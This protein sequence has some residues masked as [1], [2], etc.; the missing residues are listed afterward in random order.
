MDGYGSFSLFQG[1]AGSLEGNKVHTA[2]M[3][4]PVPQAP[5][6][7]SANPQPPRPTTAAATCPGA[8]CPVTST[9]SPAR[10]KQGQC[11][12]PLVATH[13]HGLHPNTLGHRYKYRFDAI[14]RPGTCRQAP[15]R[16]DDKAIFGNIY[17]EYMSP[18]LGFV[19]DQLL[20]LS[21]RVCRHF[22]L[23]PYFTSLSISPTTTDDIR[24][25]LSTQQQP[26]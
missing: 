2:Y 24:T 16:S 8:R 18:D 3:I 10:P 6:P 23:A 13:L 21:P 22:A 25:G 14:A 17:G 20:R 9:K 12:A 1:T 26:Q 5:R 4:I 19:P 15:S 11:R 7:P